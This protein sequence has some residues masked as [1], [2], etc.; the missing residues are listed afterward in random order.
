MIKDYFYVCPDGLIMFAHSYRPKW[1]EFWKRHFYLTPNE[2]EYITVPE[3]GIGPQPEE[4]LK[5]Y[6]KLKKHLFRTP[7][8]LSGYMYYVVV[9]CGKFCPKIMGYD[10]RHVKY[11]SYEHENY[12]IK[13]KYHCLYSTPVFVKDVHKAEFIKSRKYADVV[14]A[15]CRQAGIEGATV[16]EIY[17]Y[18]SNSLLY[19]NIVVVL[20]HKKDKNCKPEF[21]RKYDGSCKIQKTSELGLAKRFT[22]DEYLNLYEQLKLSNKEYMILPKILNNDGWS[23]KPEDVDGKESIKLT[24]RL[25][26]ND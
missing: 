13:N 9:S 18:R 10:P 22:Y 2:Y 4:V 14:A 7:L 19:A 24:Y 12:S 21:L 25:H 23:G 5:A 8:Q 16:R 26:G 1:W 3:Y 20:S 15:R 17:I 11:Y 6:P